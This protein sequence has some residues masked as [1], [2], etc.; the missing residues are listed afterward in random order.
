MMKKMMLM[1]FAIT[2]TTMGYAAS[3]SNIPDE[4]QSNVEVTFTVN[5][6]DCN[7]GVSYE[8]YWY[9]TLEEYVIKFYNNTDSYVSITYQYRVKDGENSSHWRDGYAGCTSGGTSD[10]NPAG[11]WGDVRDVEYEKK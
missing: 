4:P 11:E 1:L 10:Y 9:S 6:L 8:V 7:E 2:L 5:G 3:T